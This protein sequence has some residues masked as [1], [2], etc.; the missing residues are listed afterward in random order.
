MSSVPRPNE[1]TCGNPFA[2]RDP[3]DLGV[4][5]PAHQGPSYLP[6]LKRVPELKKQ[7]PNGAKRPQLARRSNFRTPDI[8][9]Y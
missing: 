1:N 9:T 2:R 6:S 5:R 3:G 8:E 4:P 7:T